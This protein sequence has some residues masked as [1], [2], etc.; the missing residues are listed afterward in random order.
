[1]RANLGI[2]SHWIV[3]INPEVMFTLQDLYE[4]HMD[5]VKL[6]IQPECVVMPV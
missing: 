5:L 4:A 2:D 6:E 3:L 1:M